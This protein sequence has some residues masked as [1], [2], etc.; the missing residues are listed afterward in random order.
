MSKNDDLKKLKE[1]ND[2]LEFIYDLQKDI[3]VNFDKIT[4]E[5]LTRKYLP[6]AHAYR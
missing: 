4:G 1:R 5:E 2:E 3:I 6:H